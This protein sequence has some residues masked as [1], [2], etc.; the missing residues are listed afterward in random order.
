[1]KGVDFGRYTEWGGSHT[2]KQP[3]EFVIAALTSGD[4]FTTRGEKNIEAVKAEPVKM[5]YHFYEFGTNWL[6]QVDITIEAM[7]LTGAYGV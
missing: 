2:A 5:L 1:M 3:V 4:R 7:K 6:P